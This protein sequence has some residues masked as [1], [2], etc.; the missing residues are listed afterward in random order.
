MSL[1]QFTNNSYKDSSKQKKQIGAYIRDD[2]LSGN[3]A[4][5]YYNPDN[6]KTIVSHTGTNSLTDWMTDAFYVNGSL[7]NT[8]RYEHAKK[9]QKQAEQKYGSENVTTTGHS[10]G[11]QLA[12][13]VGKH[14]DHV[15]TYNRPV[16]P[17]EALTHKLPKNQTDIRTSGD[18]VSLISPF[19]RMRNDQIV[20]P[21]KT[22][23]PL[24]EH[25]SGALK[26]TRGNIF[27]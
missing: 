14:S 24:V 22:Y 19:Q 27:F 25:S 11:A 10:L 9:V 18:L 1:Q 3:R 20:I 12:E 26:E 5:V 16:T 17:F 23:N 6:G 2:S 13:K 8:K 4:Q 15:Y 7:K 21:S